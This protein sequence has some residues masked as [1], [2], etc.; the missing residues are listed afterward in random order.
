MPDEV[1]VK[2]EEI[3]KKFCKSLKRSMLYGIQDIARDTFSLR[4]FKDG[5]RKDEFW[6]VDDIS[7]E[8]KRGE[9]LGLIGPNGAGK[10]TLLKVLNG[11]ILPDRGCA[12]IRGRV[13]ALIEI[14]A[15][16][17]PMLTGR[18]NVYINGSILGF[19]KKEIARK[20]DEIVEFS[21]LSE[22]ID[23]PVKHYSSGMYVRLGFAIAAQMK[24]DVLLVDEVLAVGDVDFRAKCFNVINNI[25]RRAAVILVSHSMPDISRV[26]SEIMVLNRGQSEFHGNEVARGIDYY[27]SLFEGEKMSVSGSGRATIEKIELASKGKKNIEQIDYLDDLDVHLNAKV[28]PTIANPNLTITFYNRSLQQV[29]QWGSYYQGIKIENRNGELNI[30]IK[31]NEINLS[32]SVY[33]L[34]VT[35][36]DSDNREILIRYF[37]EKKLSILGTF[38]G[39]TAVQLKANAI[40]K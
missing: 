37:A 25:M 22:F 20:F 1:L 11:I 35:I 15:G 27:Y 26:C 40:I 31:F 5:L 24:P 38:I 14:G 8:L 6:A 39:Y 19:S 18:E 28:D 3:S 9:C 16:F 2:V 30:I 10:S 36:L 34:T 23:T 17:H 29:S 4:P 21:E 7:F 32:P 33:Y 13:G 12:E